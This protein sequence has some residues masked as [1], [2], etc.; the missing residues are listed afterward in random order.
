MKLTQLQYFRTICEYNNITRAA[1]ALHVSQPSLSKA[2]RE[3]EEE[4]GITL[5]RRL[6]KGLALTEEGEI[7]L[8][9]AKKLLDQADALT[10]RMDQIRIKKQDVRLGVPPML[11][12]LIFP[13]LLQAYRSRFPGARLQIAENGTL[14][15][16][17]MVLDGTL[18]AAIISHDGAL[19]AAFH[20]TDLLSFRICF[21]LSRQNPMA[22]QTSVSMD[23]A[24]AFPLVLLAED[25]FLT[26]YLTRYYRGRGLTPNVILCTNQIDTI[27]Q[28]V[29]NNTAATF[30]FEDVLGPDPDIARLSVRDLPAIQSKLI[31][32][33]S[34]K[35]S[36]A[37]QDLI[38]LSK[39]I[40]M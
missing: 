1:R 20:Y 29:A 3:L 8:E 31:W 24:A 38:R 19:P 25:S 23:D 33:A 28:L 5:F 27:R 15:N 11:A 4:F 21:Y 7:L 22:S 36:P 14:T 13:K 30:L 9:E 39:S 32:S 40:F 34:R 6:S 35:P 26:D 18:D 17:N 10:A 12:T 2:I 37:V 16:K